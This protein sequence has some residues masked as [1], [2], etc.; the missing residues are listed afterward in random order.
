MEQGLV[1]D[2]QPASESEKRLYRLT[3][4]GKNALSHEIARLEHLVRNTKRHLQG[5]KPRRAE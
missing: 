3:T 5:M 1:R 2:L 4:A